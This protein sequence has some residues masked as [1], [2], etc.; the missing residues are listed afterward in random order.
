MGSS[1]L[2]EHGYVSD[3]MTHS[4]RKLII[5]NCADFE[6]SLRS[7]LEKHQAVTW[8]K[9]TGPSHITWNRRVLGYLVKVHSKDTAFARDWEKTIHLNGGEINLFRQTEALLGNV[10]RRQGIIAGPFIT[11]YPQKIHPRGWTVSWAEAQE[12]E[13]S[14]WDTRTSHHRTLAWQSLL[15]ITSSTSVFTPY[16]CQGPFTRTL[17]FTRC[18]SLVPYRF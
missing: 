10:L 16:T 5:A 6:T 7:D 4:F 8:R 12:E 14:F 17:M 9:K 18:P 3:K 11:H 2:A 15:N 1:W 13:D